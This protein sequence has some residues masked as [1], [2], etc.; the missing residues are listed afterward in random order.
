MSDEEFDQKFKAIADTFIDLANQHA[1]EAHVENVSIALLYAA[2]RF[3]AYVVANNAENL[4]KFE[5]DRKSASDFFQEKYQEMLQENL[6]DYSKV[7]EPQPK[8]AHLMKDQENSKAD[9]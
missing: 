4:E 8:Y 2:S 3:N 1:K 6:D 7:Y 9:V 5:S